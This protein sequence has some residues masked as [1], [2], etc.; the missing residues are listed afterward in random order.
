M[1]QVILKVSQTVVTVSL[2]GRVDSEYGFQ[3]YG[4]Q[5]GLGIEITVGS[6]QGLPVLGDCFILVHDL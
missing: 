2:G 6:V 3:A 1:V 4:F 5:A